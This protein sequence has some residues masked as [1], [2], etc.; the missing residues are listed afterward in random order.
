MSGGI[1]T[2][3]TVLVVLFIILFAFAMYFG[4][5]SLISIILSF[6]PAVY[7]YQHFP[8]AEKL[9]FLH[10]DSLIIVNKIA[11]FLL[12]LIPLNIVIGRYI[13]SESTEGATHYFRTAGYAL[14]GVIMFLIFYYGVISLASFY[15]FSPILNSLFESPSHLFWLS[16]APVLIMLF[17]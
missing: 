1:S 2:D 4:K 17:L 9:I 14:A 6:Y 13:F 8:Y 16:L 10:G 5:S 3:I 12:F 7:F 15:A 11:I